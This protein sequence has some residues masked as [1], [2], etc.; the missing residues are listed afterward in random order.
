MTFDALR[1]DALPF[2]ALPAP[3]W[4][5][6]FILLAGVLPTEI[7]RSLGVLAAGRLNEGTP[8]F[9]FVRAVATALVAAVIAQLVVFPTGV[10]ASAPLWLRLGAA[11][12][13]FA[14][15]E[16]A[17]RR[18]WVGILAGETALIGGL[19]ALGFDGALDGGA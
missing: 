19:L 12:V 3:W 6:L 15:M 14:A 2:D 17:G 10:L 8:A 5:Y 13:G 16:A 7:W 9:A 11:A 18:G 1:F 4:P